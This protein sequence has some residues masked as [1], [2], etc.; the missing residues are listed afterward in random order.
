MSESKVKLGLND[1]RVLYKNYLET[2]TMPSNP[3]QRRILTNYL[4]HIEDIKSISSNSD[5]KMIPNPSPS[6]FSQNQFDSGA[7][8]PSSITQPSYDSLFPKKEV[9]IK[10]ISEGEIEEERKKITQLSICGENSFF[11]HERVERISSKFMKDFENFKDGQKGE[12]E[13]KL[14]ELRDGMKDNSAL[15]LFEN[16]RTAAI[17]ELY[18]SFFNEYE[19]RLEKI[20]VPN[21]F[22]IFDNTEMKYSDDEVVSR[23]ENRIKQILSDRKIQVATSA[24]FETIY[25]FLIGEEQR[26]VDKIFPIEEGSSDE[27]VARIEEIRTKFIQ[28]Y[29][30]MADELKDK[31]TL[32]EIFNVFNPTETSRV[33]F[34]DMGISALNMIGL[35]NFM[36]ITFLREIMF[37][38]AP[39]SLLKVLNFHTNCIEVL[40]AMKFGDKLSK[41]LC[42]IIECLFTFQYTNLFYTAWFLYNQGIDL[43]SLSIQLSGSVQTI[44]NRISVLISILTK[45]PK[46]SMDTKYFESALEMLQSILTKNDSIVRQIFGLVAIMSDQ[47]RFEREFLIDSNTDDYIKAL[48]EAETQIKE[49]DSE[50]KGYLGFFK[51]IYGS[52]K[53]G[54]V[55]FIGKQPEPEEHISQSGIEIKKLSAKEIATEKI[56]LLK[57]IEKMKQEHNLLQPN[58][59]LHKGTSIKEAELAKDKIEEVEKEEKEE[60]KDEE[61][62]Q[63]VS[64]LGLFRTKREVEI[65]KKKLV[66]YTNKYKAINRANF[67]AIKDMVADFVSSVDS[68]NTMNL[69]TSCTNNQ[70]IKDIFA[71]R[72]TEEL[73][74]LLISKGADTRLILG[75]IQTYIKTKFP[76][77]S[78]GSIDEMRNYNNLNQMIFQDLVNSIFISSNLIKSQLRNKIK[79]ANS[80]FITNIGPSYT[81]DNII[82]P[83]IEATSPSLSDLIQIFSKIEVNPVYNL[84]ET[85]ASI[86]LGDIL[87]TSQTDQLAVEF[88]L[89]TGI[90]YF[91]LAIIILVVFGKLFRCGKRL[92]KKYMINVR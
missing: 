15:K 64:E 37:M 40:T 77:I 30:K 59:I 52:I 10:Y 14:S 24:Y 89:G 23:F 18:Y 61:V 17:D 20:N 49:E 25:N 81:N 26:N 66:K 56:N 76:K 74:E 9:E 6:V 16:A 36:N 71:S 53:S 45:I 33:P 27:H 31:N 58:H 11:N 85:P 35:Y 80:L 60:I 5:R 86:D 90:F 57:E 87:D 51:K 38:H 21:K 22:F 50:G 2:N 68:G 43:T 28:K 84:Y 72:T 4:K 55:K 7:D 83:L 12:I 78:K 32:W 3:T 46:S 62:A 13:E 75:D 1:P 29:R 41:Y 48:Q 88:S 91:S 70:L 19:C 34:V 54:S 67:D 69:I 63:Y 79:T 44:T 39:I 92:S 47:E 65:M 8:I 73:G 82:R 42:F